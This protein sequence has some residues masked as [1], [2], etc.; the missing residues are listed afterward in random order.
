MT[1]I[2]IMCIVERMHSSAVNGIGHA[3]TCMMA[4]RGTGRLSKYVIIS[5]RGSL[6]VQV[7]PHAVFPVEQEVPLSVVRPVPQ[8]NRCAAAH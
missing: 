7:L 6:A 8:R 3:L 1:G 2:I 4:G 5:G